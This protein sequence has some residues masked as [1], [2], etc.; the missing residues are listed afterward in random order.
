MGG[1]GS[2]FLLYTSILFFI[3]FKYEIIV[4]TSFWSFVIQIPIQAVCAS[5]HLFPSSKQKWARFYLDNIQM[6][7][8]RLHVNLICGLYFCCNWAEIKEH[9]AFNSELKMKEHF[10][11]KEISFN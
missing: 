10:H 5:L 9:L 1:F 3:F 8:N 2:V 11:F 6:T 4:R 7:L